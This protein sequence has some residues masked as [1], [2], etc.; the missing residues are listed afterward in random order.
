VSFVFDAIRDRRL[1]RRRNSEAWADLLGS[2]SA[3]DRE[4]TAQLA[5]MVASSR[6]VA[7]PATPQGLRYGR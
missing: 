5:P 3:D 4:R 6:L 7:V 2:T 1:R